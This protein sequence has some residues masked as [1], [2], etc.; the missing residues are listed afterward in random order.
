[1]QEQ[2]LIN[3]HFS[4]GLAIRN[5]FG[6]QKSWSKLLASYGI[7]HPDNA[8]RLIIRAEWLQLNG[9]YERVLTLIKWRL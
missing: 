1:M 9:D 8:A 2:D 5:A 3:L 7:E 6:L 4:P